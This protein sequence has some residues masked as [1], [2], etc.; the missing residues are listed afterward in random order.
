[1]RWVV[2]VLPG[3]FPGTF[4]FSMPITF[5]GWR[6]QRSLASHSVNYSR[7]RGESTPLNPDSCTGSTSFSEPKPG[8]GD[9][10]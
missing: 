8:I 5:S 9:V 2:A 7:L 1:V 4:G 6:W 10:V 3:V